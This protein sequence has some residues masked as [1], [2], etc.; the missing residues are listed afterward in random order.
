[1]GEVKVKQLSAK[2][3]ASGLTITKTAITSW[4]VK[5]IDKASGE[6]IYAN[7][8]LPKAQSFGSED[9]ALAEIGRQVGEEFTKRFFM[10]KF[11][12]GTQKVAFTLGGLPAGSETM[13]LRELKSLRGV[14]DAQWAGGK[15]ML[16]VAEG[17]PPDVIDSAVLKPL[18]A[19]L[20]A[21]C[22][23]LGNSAGADVSASLN[24]QCTAD[25]MKSK[26]ESTPPAGWL[27]APEARSKAVRKAA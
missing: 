27:N 10:E 2:L 7:T 9:Q 19:K 20:G 16:S 15:F 6:E 17:S 1:V 3:A 11:N 18:N 23:S 26:L 25:S 4:T 8:Q 12:F 13:F 24:A 5:A 22:F 21:A 14:L